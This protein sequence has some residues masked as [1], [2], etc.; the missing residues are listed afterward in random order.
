MRTLVSALIAF[1]LIT[2]CAQIRSEFVPQTGEPMRIYDQ[3]HTRTGVATVATGKDEVRDAS[4]NLVATSTHYQDRH[5]QY[6]ERVFYPMQGA[7][8][9]DDE[10]FYRITSDAEATQAYADYHKSGKRRNTIGIVLGS[11]GLGL[12]GTGIGLSASDLKKTQPSMTYVGPA[13]ATVGLLSGV[14]G[15]VLIVM[16]RKAAKNPEMRLFED[17]QRLKADAARYNAQLGLQPAR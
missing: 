12:F 11:I 13:I 16:G 3:T 17:P 2:G 9:I 4:G 15:I 10:S 8:R 14:A 6:R 7:A 5:F 1:P